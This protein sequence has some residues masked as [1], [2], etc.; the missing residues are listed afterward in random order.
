MCVYCILCSVY[1]WY[2]Y[3]LYTIYKR[4]MNYTYKLYIHTHTHIYIYL[5]YMAKVRVC[6]ERGVQ[7]IRKGSERHLC[8]H[9]SIM[10]CYYLSS[11]LLFTI[12]III[13]C[14]KSNG[15]ISHRLV[16][17]IN[18]SSVSGGLP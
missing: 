8:G 13:V 6:E 2:I 16:Q 17:H 11:C 9:P 4:I 5:F 15:I 1:D 3:M 18:T 10:Y 12:I 14:I 7:P